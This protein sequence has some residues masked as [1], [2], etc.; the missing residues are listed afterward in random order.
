MVPRGAFSF[1]CL[2]VVEFGFAEG[3]VLEAVAFP[4]DGD[5]AGVMEEAVEDGAG[6]G[7]LL[8]VRA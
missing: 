7:S 2:G 1:G 8:R 3:G 6:G 5:E 4:G